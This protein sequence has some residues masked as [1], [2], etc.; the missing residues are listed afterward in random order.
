VQTREGL[1]VG[2]AVGFGYRLDPSKLAL[3][4]FEP[5]QPV[6]EEMIAPTVASAF[7]ELAPSYL[8][9][10]LFSTKR[11]NVD[12]PRARGSRRVGCGRHRD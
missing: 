5:A 8:V 7:R 1:V 10:E 2:L 12:R 3:H 9:R 6:D 4:S 11:M